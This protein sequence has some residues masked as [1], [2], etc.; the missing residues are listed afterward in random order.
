M[1]K[2]VLLIQQKNH[3]KTTMLNLMDSFSR[4]V[5]KKPTSL[6]RAISLVRQPVLRII[7]SH[8]KSSL[9]N[10]RVIRR[11]VMHSWLVKSR[12][13]TFNNKGNLIRRNQRITSSSKALTL[14]SH[15]LFMLTNPRMKLLKGIHLW[16][17]T[18]FQKS[19]KVKTSLCH[20]SIW[21]WIG[22]MIKQM[23]CKSLLLL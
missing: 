11:Q 9:K 22:K 13:R 23:N 17:L 15:N 5:T 10:K 3:T 7:S 12:S 1:Q 2:L 6:T 19:A 18:K 4:F 21:I 8:K 16:F 14:S 20:K